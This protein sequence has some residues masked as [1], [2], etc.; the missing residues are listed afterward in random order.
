MGDDAFST[1]TGVHAAAVAKAYE[2]GEAW[3]ADR[4][5]SSVPAGMVG[6]EQ[7]IL[8]GPMSGKWNALFWLR[9]HG[10]AETPGLV[11]AMLNAAKQSAH[12]LSDEE[13]KTLLKS[14]TKSAASN[15]HHE[16]T[17]V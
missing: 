14:V 10:Y 8:V 15:R 13:M 1:S 16:E 4:I 7:R 9:Q 2:K 12:V 6:R 11:A 3:L 5:Y 17:P